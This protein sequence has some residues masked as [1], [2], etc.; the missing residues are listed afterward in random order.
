MVNLRVIPLDI[1]VWDDEDKFDMSGKSSGVILDEFKAWI[2]EQKT[3]TSGIERARWL[4]KGHW[5]NKLIL[6][7]NIT[8]QTV[9]YSISYDILCMLLNDLLTGQ[10]VDNAQLIV[11]EGTFSDTATIGKGWTS[12]FCGQ[13]S[14]GK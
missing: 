1:K 9:G 11:P 12:A 13:Y 2:Q 8:L 10:S 4:R 7:F 5:H 14:N 6:N 3:K